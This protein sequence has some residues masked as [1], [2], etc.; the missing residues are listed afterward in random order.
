MLVIVINWVKKFP[1]NRRNKTNVQTGT[2][3]DR[4]SRS[5]KKYGHEMLTNY[6]NDDRSL[7][8]KPWQHNPTD[9]RQDSSKGSQPKIAYPG[10][11]TFCFVH[12][13]GSTDQSCPLAGDVITDAVRQQLGADTPLTMLLSII[14][15]SI[16]L[17][18]PI[19]F[20]RVMGLKITI[21]RQWWKFPTHHQHTVYT[22]STHCPHTINSLSTHCIHTIN[23]V[24]TPSTHYL[25]TI[26][27]LST[28][29]IHTINFVY[30]P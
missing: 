16:P 12:C 1:L 24:Y 15:L 18:D 28:H 22:P 21:K 2:I 14:P 8:K 9:N 30:T 23:F 10:M 29:C 7:N 25:H 11:P 3:M 6:S 4:Q 27:T 19:P 17:S 13:S 5:N 26:N 20:A